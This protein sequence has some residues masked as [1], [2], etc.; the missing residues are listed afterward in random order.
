[1]KHPDFYSGRLGN[2]MFQLAYLY[3]RMKE[4]TIPDWYLQD[5]AY[6]A[7]HETDI[8]ELFSDGIGYLEQVGV[9]VRRATNPINPDEPAYKDNPFYVNLSDTDYYQRAMALFQPTENFVIFS[10]DP[11]WCKEHFKGNNIQVMDRGNDIEDFNILASCKAQII[12]N[13][14]F[15]WWAAFLNPNPAKKVIAPKQWYSDG[16]ERTKCPDSW[17]RI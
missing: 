16:V 13:S 11:E 9:H 10:D 2:R 17:I 15:S 1:M 6:F 4:G 5:P 8:Q 12:A 3:A 7:G 14:S